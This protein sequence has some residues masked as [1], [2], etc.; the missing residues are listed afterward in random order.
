MMDP[1][2]KRVTRYGVEVLS[3]LALLALLAG[4]GGDSGALPASDLDPPSQYTLGSGDH[5]HIIVYGEQD[6]TGD[7]TVEGSG[8]LAFPLIGNVMARGLTT[9]QLE[10]TLNSK[11]SPQYL[12]NPSIN[13]SVTTYRPFYIVGE[14]KNPGSYSY[15]DGMSVMNAV[16]LAG[17]FTYRAREDE[18]YITRDTPDGHGVADQK[19]L[20]YQQTPM[21]PGDI[22]TVRERYF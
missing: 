2:R 18:F 10:R 14:V 8:N 17:G 5:L 13:V 6:M 15:V 1:G 21:A 12:K 9:Q 22:I 19:Y 11:L 20:A 16:A 7:Y 3:T 4:C